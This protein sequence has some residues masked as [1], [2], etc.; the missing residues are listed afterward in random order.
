MNTIKDL[1]LTELSKLKEFDL[2]KLQQEL[3]GALKKMFE[4][5]TKLELNELK[6]THLLKFMRRYIAQINTFINQK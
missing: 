1:K 4:L 6:Q 5:R 2:G 3:K